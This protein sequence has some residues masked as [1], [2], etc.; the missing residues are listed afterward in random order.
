MSDVIWRPTPE[1][2]Q[3]SNV[4]RFMARHG[5]GSYDELVRRSVEDVAWYWSATERDLGLT[6]IRPYDSVRDVHQG[7]EWATW[8]GGG[9]INI[10]DNCVDRHAA[11]EEVLALDAAAFAG[12]V[13]GD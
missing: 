4:A 8:F 10:A 3:R 5:I 2:L 12:E 11:G 6:W 9:Q 13:A 1:H 7:V